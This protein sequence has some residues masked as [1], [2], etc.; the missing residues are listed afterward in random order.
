MSALIDQHTTAAKVK[1]AC[2]W[3]SFKHARLQIS[4]GQDYHEGDRLKATLEWASNNFDTVTV[5]VND[6]LQRHNMEF[7]GVDAKKA[8]DLSENNGREWIERNIETMRAYPNIRIVRWNE[9][10]GRKE[11]PQILQKMHDL[12]NNSSSMK[13]AV[14][15]EIYNFWKRRGDGV[16]EHYSSFHYHAKNYLLEECAVFSMMFSEQEAA[17][18]YPGSTLLPCALF[19]DMG[20]YGFTRIEFKSQ[21][22]QVA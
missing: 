7:S 1:R 11:Y 19:K 3:D 22:L 13:D 6:T 12:Y 5:C 15:T 10:A 8:L 9:W 21:K 2:Q 20:K 18:I 16:Q 14:E 17:D 4:V